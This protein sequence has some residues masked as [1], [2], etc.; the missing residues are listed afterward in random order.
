[1]E[2]AGVEVLD[3]VLGDDVELA[4]HIVHVQLFALAGSDGDIEDADT[5]VLESDVVIAGAARTASSL[6]GHFEG[7]MSG[8]AFH[9]PPKRLPP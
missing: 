6:A 9:E 1:M 4:G 7:S 2:P 3:V 8:V 5:I